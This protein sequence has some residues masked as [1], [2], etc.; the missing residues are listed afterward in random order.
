[1]NRIAVNESF[2]KA[3]GRCSPCNVESEEDVDETE[4]AHY[5]LDYLE[6]LLIELFPFGCLM[7][8][9]L[10]TLNNLPIREDTNT[11]VESWNKVC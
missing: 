3:I 2:Y 6:Y 10:L 8:H 11:E 7:D 1:M 4:N 9:S 5:N